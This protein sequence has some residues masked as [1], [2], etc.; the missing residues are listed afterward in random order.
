MSKEWDPEN[1]FEVLGNEAVRRILAL[2]AVEPVSAQEIAD[3]LDASEATIY[4]QIDACEQYDLLRA[5]RRIDEA[6]N[7][8]EVYETVL[9]RACVEVT[10]GEI[11]L[12]ITLRR[13][14]L[15]QF[16]DPPVDD[17]TP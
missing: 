2:A 17:E 12:D 15:D 10:P 8:Y 1:V 3:H 6:G 13:D 9:E 5:D 11:E 16:E 4:R 7:H 14:V